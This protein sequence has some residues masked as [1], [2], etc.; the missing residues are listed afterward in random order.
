MTHCEYD[1]GYLV[2]NAFN[3]FNGNKEV[4]R[5]A[6]DFA[7]GEVATH[8]LPNEGQRRVVTSGRGRICASPNSRSGPDSH[9][10]RFS[11]QTLGARSCTTC[12][13]GR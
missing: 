7:E 10:R 6:N 9:I 3:A 11:P 5:L 13:R 2:F 1:D 12:T 8:S 4:W